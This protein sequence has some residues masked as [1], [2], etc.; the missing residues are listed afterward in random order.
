MNTSSG[1]VREMQGFRVGKGILLKVELPA[2]YR[3]PTVAYS[4]TLE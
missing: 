3:D 2:C 4:Q 1:P